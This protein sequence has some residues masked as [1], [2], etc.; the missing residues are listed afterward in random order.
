MSELKQLRVER[1][2][3]D[4]VNINYGWFVHVTKKLGFK[5]LTI[6]LTRD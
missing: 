2:S 3:I 1:E 4:Y 6:N 5:I